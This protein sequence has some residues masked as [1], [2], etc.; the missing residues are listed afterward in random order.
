[1]T[2]FSAILIA[3][4]PATG[5]SGP[6]PDSEIPALDCATVPSVT[7]GNWAHGYFT[8]QCEG[9]HA[10]NTPNRYGAPPAV[11]FDSEADVVLRKERVY[12]R[13]LVDATMPPAGGL[14]DDDRNLLEIYLSC[15][16]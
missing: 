8:T 7:W 4:V 5:D 6:V 3:C 1:M 11:T 13:V 10:V 14:T 9:C 15:G 16:I 2:L 12:A